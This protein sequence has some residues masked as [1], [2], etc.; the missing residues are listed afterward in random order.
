MNTEKQQSVHLLIFPWLISSGASLVPIILHGLSHSFIF[1]L[2]SIQF[3]SLIAPPPSWKTFFFQIPIFHPSCP[4]K[5]LALNHLSTSN[6]KY[7]P[8]Q[9]IIC[10]KW[11]HEN[12][13]NASYIT[14]WCLVLNPHSWTARGSFIDSIYILLLPFITFSMKHLLLMQAQRFKLGVLG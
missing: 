11:I 4:T 3:C 7:R 14:R 9:I 8:E 1:H 10:L 6:R 2:F 5:T 12:S 13:S